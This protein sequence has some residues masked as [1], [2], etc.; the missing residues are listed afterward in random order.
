MLYCAHQHP[1]R[2]S[3]IP[4]MNALLAANRDNVHRHH[5][6]PKANAEEWRAIEPAKQVVCTFRNDAYLFEDFVPWFTDGV[7]C[8]VHLCYQ[9]REVMLHLSNVMW[10]KAERVI[11]PRAPRVTVAKARNGKLTKVELEGLL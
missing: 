4:T 1:L 8:I 2:P 6:I 9:D 3:P 7:R 5:L 11:K 10:P